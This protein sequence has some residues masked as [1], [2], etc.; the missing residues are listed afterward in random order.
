MTET[1]LSLHDK[2]KKKIK[3]WEG[4]SDHL[5]DLITVRLENSDYRLKLAGCKQCIYVH[6]F[7]FVLMHLR[8]HLS[9]RTEVFMAKSATFTQSTVLGVH[10]CVLSLL[11]KTGKWSKIFLT[12]SLTQV[13]T[14]WYYSF[15]KLWQIYRYKCGRYLLS[16]YFQN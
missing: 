14:L 11:N 8:M 4:F 16:G 3:V 12:S 1:Q 7:I 2:K 10:S 6:I 13:E 5:W 9:M 15:S